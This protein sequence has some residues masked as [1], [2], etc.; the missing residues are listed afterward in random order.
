[1]EPA[2]P[3]LVKAPLP[4]KVL[5]IAVKPGDKVK[6]DQVILVLESMKMENDIYAPKSGEVKEVKTSVG[7]TVATGDILVVID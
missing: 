3:G 7:A 4:G 2:A 1:M 6:L 5:S